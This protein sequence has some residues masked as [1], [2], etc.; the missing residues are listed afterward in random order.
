MATSKKSGPSQ[1]QPEPLVAG[2]PFTIDFLLEQVFPGE[3]KKAVALE[4]SGY[5]IEVFPL[6][7]RF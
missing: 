1:P 3:E 6:F 2:S 5:N 7:F 4:L